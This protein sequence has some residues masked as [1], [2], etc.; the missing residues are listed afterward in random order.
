VAQVVT[1]AASQVGASVV[2]C[3]T[4]RGAIS[5]LESGTGHAAILELP[6]PDI[7]GV[8]VLSALRDRGMPVVV[9]AEEGAEDCA[10]LASQ[11]GATAFLTK[12]IDAAQALSML[13]ASLQDQSPSAP[14]SP[15]LS[16][17]KPRGLPR[18]QKE[19][20]R[21]T[22]PPIGYPLGT[23][24]PGN[25]PED[26]D[27]M[28]FCPARPALEETIL[29]PLV[30]SAPEGLAQ[31]L[32]A[33][34]TPIHVPRGAGAPVLPQG[35]LG[36]TRVPQ[37][38]A[39]IHA[40]PTTGALALGS[41][42]VK[43]LVLFENGK[44]V[45]AVSNLPSERF[46]AR[47]LREGVLSAEMLNAILAEIGPKKP[48]NEA[49]VERGILADPR[50][51]AMIADQVRQILWSTF[52]WRQGTY[53]LSPGPRPRRAIAPIEISIPQ[54]VLEGVDRM[55]SLERL[56][57]QLVDEMALAP[58]ADPAIDLLEL[59]LSPV[60]ESMIASA[61]GTKTVRDLVLLSGL[62]E[63]SALALLQACCDLELLEEV[64]RGLAVTR[65]IGFL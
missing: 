27:S 48:L 64:P 50:R 2:L 22:V 46:S 30:A 40:M 60:Q 42:A 17:R 20:A 49:L 11:F 3:R 21:T 5:R 7:G 19:A 61:D 10:V 26:F 28:I 43:K 18:G 4:G 59:A 35:N 8:A 29:M 62:D 54:T 13:A 23:A 63:R 32:P 33:P 41:G 31:P 25:L 52:E 47:C 6:L 16:T 39:R 57:E 56:R 58:T 36:P 44:A 9:I 37:L 45:F 14:T 38:L 65:R 53:R 12:P 15:A 34:A 24:L 1:R 51:T 55:A